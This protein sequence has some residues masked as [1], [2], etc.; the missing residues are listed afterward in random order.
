MRA[1]ILLLVLALG[2]DSGAE[3]LAAVLSHGEAKCDG[4]GRLK[5]GR[6][7]LDGSYSTCDVGSDEWLCMSVRAQRGCYRLVPVNP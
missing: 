7:Y 5:L 4:G 1:L 2:C 3:T 6:T